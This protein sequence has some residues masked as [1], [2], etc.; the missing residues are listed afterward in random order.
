MFS[1]FSGRKKNSEKPGNGASVLKDFSFLQTDIHSHLVPGIDDGSGSVEDSLA[2]L[3]QLRSMGFRQFITTPHIKWEKYPNTNETIRNGLQILHNALQEKNID[4]TVRAAAEY[5][6][7]DHFLSLL[8]KNEPL[9]TIQKNE[10]LVEFSFYAEPFQPQHTFFKIQTAGYQPILAHPERYGYFHDKKEA[11]RSIKDQ[12]VFLQLNLLA[13]TGYYG[14]KV[15]QTSQ[16]L[17]QEGLYDYCGTDLH[18]DK[19]AEALQQLAGSKLLHT[20]QQYP[21]R[22]NSIQTTGVAADQL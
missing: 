18:H 14:K 8:Q 17:L 7:D 5:F 11:Y 13:L 16:W 9:L 1:I 20:L 12:G 4:I 3:E 15:Q 10:I 22:N 21:F 2:L 6:L 19:H